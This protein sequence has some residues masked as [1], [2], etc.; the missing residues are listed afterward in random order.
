MYDIDDYD[1]NP[2]AYRPGDELIQGINSE[3]QFRNFRQARLTFKEKALAAI[4]EWD[5]CET[6]F[7]WYLYCISEY[8]NDELHPYAKFSLKFDR[9]ARISN[10]IDWDSEDIAVLNEITR[11]F[12]D[13]DPECGRLAICQKPV[14]QIDTMIENHHLTVIRTLGLFKDENGVRGRLYCK[15]F[16]PY[17][18]A[19]F[20]EISDCTFTRNLPELAYWYC[21]LSAVIDSESLN[22]SWWDNLER[23]SRSDLY[24]YL[25]R[26]PVGISVFEEESKQ[27]VLNIVDLAIQYMEPFAE[28]KRQ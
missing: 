11:Y 17:L 14:W 28:I 27:M 6:L 1:F 16:K 4:K 15:L 19:I 24:E 21:A 22:N 9:S 20:D 13:S 2:D 26:K 8:A 23:M 12:F 3:Y 18:K 7:N 5:L 10:I 25:C